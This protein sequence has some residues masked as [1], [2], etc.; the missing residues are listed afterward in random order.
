MIKIRDELTVLT[1]FSNNDPNLSAS[2][3]KLGR[4]SG[5]ACQHSLMIAFLKDKNQSSYY[6]NSAHYISEE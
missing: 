2:S 5:S 1:L 3:E 6:R 4:S